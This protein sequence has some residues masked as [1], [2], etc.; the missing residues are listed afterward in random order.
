MIHDEKARI[1]CQYQSNPQVHAMVVLTLLTIHQIFSQIGE[2]PS[3]IPQFWKLCVLQKNTWR[4]P[5]V[6]QLPSLHLVRKYAW[7]ILGHYLLP[8]A[9]SFPWAVR[10]WKTV[11]IL[12]QIMSIDK[13]SK[14][15]TIMYFHATCTASRGYCLYNHC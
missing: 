14:H 2:Y 1:E 13:I 15:S 12:E 10:S 11:C 4:A 5:T 6:T 8:K 3:A 7:I 9:Q